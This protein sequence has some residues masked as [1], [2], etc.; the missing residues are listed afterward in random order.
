MPEGRIVKALSGF[1]YVADGDRVYQC[2]ARGLFKKKGAKVHPLVGDWVVYDV[3]SDS[4][5][6]VMEVGERTSELVRPPIANVDQAVLVFSM[7]EPAFS[8]FLLDK[9]LVHTEHAGIDAVI[10][11]SKSDIAADDDVEAVVR[12]YEKIGYRVIPTSTVDMRGVEALREALRDSIS[13]FA[14][15]SG[16]G[17]SSLINALFPGIS[18]QTGDVSQKLGRGRHTTRHVELIPLPGG[19]YVADTPGFSS[20]EFIG[21]DELD[22]A[23]AFRDFGELSASCKFR[24]CLHVSEPGC[25]V[26]AALDAGELDTERYQHY[27]Q[28]REELKEYQRRNKPW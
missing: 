27:K 22:L 8:P 1:Y 7:A 18:L 15:Q 17:K 24:G 13:V 16:V 6:Y 21:I 12:K 26:L 19:G 23:E 3:I 11:L 2:R 10:V 5:G 9:F 20:L 4:E 25:A 14:G 28:F